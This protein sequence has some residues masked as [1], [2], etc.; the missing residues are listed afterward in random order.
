[1]KL[2]VVIRMLM[3]VAEEKRVV[4]IAILFSTWAESR[5]YRIKNP[6]SK[7]GGFFFY[8]KGFASFY[9]SL[10]TDFVFVINFL[11]YSI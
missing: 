8:K 2:K 3:A 1:M 11:F 4:V 6:S 5:S 10:F 7:I 9:Y